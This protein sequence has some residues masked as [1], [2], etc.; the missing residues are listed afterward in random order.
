MIKRFLLLLTLFLLVCIIDVS[1]NTY[2]GGNQLVSED[3]WEQ[4]KETELLMSDL[5]YSIFDNYGYQHYFNRELWEQRS[6]I[7][8]GDYRSIYPNDFKEATQN[9]TG[10]AYYNGGEYRYH[11]YSQDGSKLNN[12]EF[13]DDAV[14]NN[15]LLTRNWIYQPWQKNSIGQ[16]VFAKFI[17]ANPSI[18]N[19][20]ALNNNTVEGNLLAKWINQSVDFIRKGT[21]TGSDYASNLDPVHYINI[22][23]VP[24]AYSTG[25]GTMFH[26]AN[27]NKVYYQSFP[28]DRYQK[29]QTD[30]RAEIAEIAVV[31][32]SEAGDITLEIMV[33]GHINDEKYIN[34]SILES[35][36]YTRKDIREW[37]FTLKNNLTSKD[38]FAKGLARDNNRTGYYLFE[39]Q[40]TRD[41]YE[42]LL[43]KNNSF[44]LNFLLEA[45][46]I[47]ATG[48][49]GRAQT[50]A[51]KRI[52]G[53]IDTKVVVETE[54]GISF[55]IRA[56]TQMLD[57]DQFEL[58][59]WESDV[60]AAV[61]RYVEIDGRRLDSNDER[62]F[63]AGE[64]QFPQIRE[65]RIYNYSVN[66]LDAAGQQFFYN[67]AVVVYDSVPRA[68]IRVAGDFKENRK[69]SVTADETISSSYLRSRTTIAI[70]KFQIRSANG[71]PLYY[72]TNNNRLKEF[73]AKNSGEVIIEI[74]V[75]SQH[76]A[77][78][79][80]LELFIAPDYP[81]DI[82][83]FVWNNLLVRDEGLDLICDASSL[84]GDHIAEL[85]YK[86]YYEAAV[87]ES[88]LVASGLYDASFTYSPSKLGSY[89][90][91]F[92]ARENFGETT[93][94][95]HI[96]A[97]DY[98]QTVVEREFFVDNLVPV[99]KL[100][101]DIERVLPSA[102][103]TILLD[104]QLDDETRDFLKDSR[105]D[106][107]NSFRLS[108][109]NAIIRFWDLKTYL[110]EQTAYKT[111]A[112]GR[113]H[114]PANYQYSENDYNG[115]LDLTT[116]N[117][118]Y[119]TVDQGSYYPFSDSFTVTSAG[120]GYSYSVYYKGV[121]QSGHNT[122]TPSLQYY[123]EGGYSGYLYKDSAWQSGKDTVVDGDYMY[124]TIHYTAF[125]TG[126]VTRSWQE[127]VPNY[128]TIDDY[129]GNYSGLV[130][131]EIIQDF[132]LDLIDESSKYIVY[133]TADQVSNFAD[134]EGIYKQVPAI[135]TILVGATGSD[136]QLA[137][138]YFV[139]NNN[140]NA[141]IIDQLIS[142]VSGEQEL[143]PRTTVLLDEKFDLKYSDI[144][145]EGDPIVEMGIQY[146]HD[147]N[148][149]DNSLGLELG[150][151]ATYSEGGYVD[152][153]KNSFTK[154][155]HFTIHRRV[156]DE[157]IGQEEYGAY[158]NIAKLE[159]IAH[160][161]PIAKLQAITEY[162][163]DHAIYN[164]SWIDFS[165]DPDFQYSKD[166]KGIVNSNF[167]YK[168]ADTDWV[169]GKPTELVPGEYQFEYVVMDCYGIWSEPFKQT[170]RLSISP[171]QPTIDIV[172]YVNHTERW[173]ENRIKYNRSKT[174]TDNQPNSYDVFFP[175]EEFMLKSNTIGN[176]DNVF[177]EIIGTRYS[178]YLMHEGNGVWTGSL[179]HQD[180]FKWGARNLIFRFIAIKETQPVKY[181]DV[182]I[183]IMG[184]QYWMQH[185]LF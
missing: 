152:E 36:Y 43:D 55:Y 39:L 58:V 24:S 32:I 140:D 47:F 159:I 168:S 179:W 88:E 148:F 175:G 63:L 93:I 13:P 91:V 28:I 92:T 177:V 131:K 145:Y 135:S 118:Y 96:Y 149:L 71:E 46:A 141:A 44:N 151:R 102:E 139:E 65:D 6:L 69:I 12:V 167:K 161:K 162:D 61:D 87:G 119:Y 27:N 183:K 23:S 105:I 138:D 95:E 122:D 111:L 7:V 33:K 104:E 75:E 109:I 124:V 165:Y 29:E 66:Y 72:G 53:A 173:N 164:I 14:G 16:P 163:Y 180:M 133:F 94:A 121:W 99:T 129:Y 4:Y 57:V 154:P 103:L 70:S 17:G 166:N 155:G 85:N 153:L 31:A 18:Y 60:S 20:T 82:I 73:L 8:Y 112:T 110:S 100:Y 169:Y 136:S 143:E 108:G 84:D 134:Y 86:I 59:L 9:V 128:V 10:I 174:G 2:Q 171:P 182:P 56:P 130:T 77:R 107:I 30:I 74:I 62:L 170:L 38:L 147:A 49:K 123:D 15:N 5:P 80:Q 160:R 116:V 181:Y 101:T 42:S 142:I 21:R 157:P 64:Y 178:T 26:L 158:S 19:I 114:P 25:Q 97:S 83:A 90:I 50:N 48:D 40:L 132:N 144:D 78:E 1:A 68:Q 113:I 41:N 51:S 176:P 54:K 125:Y 67:S 117:N 45:E 172:G 52:T 150:A 35:I 89:K 127:W 184:D 76:G 22:D 156:K 120:H 34:N 185:R 146:V 98:R 11:G 3:Y 79:Y 126:L 81:P 37:N 106:I 137:T 115:L